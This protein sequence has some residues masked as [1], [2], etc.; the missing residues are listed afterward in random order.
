M[1]TDDE[2]PGRSDELPHVPPLHQA[3]LGPREELHP[4]LADPLDAVHGVPVAVTEVRQPDMARPSSLVKEADL[5]VIAAGSQET[6]FSLIELQGGDVAGPGQ[7]GLVAG[8]DGNVRDVAVTAGLAMAA[9][10]HGAAV[11]HGHHPA[12]AGGGLLPGQTTDRSSS[13]GEILQFA[14]DGHAGLT[15]SIIKYF[16]IFSLVSEVD[17]FQIY[18]VVFLQKF[19]DS[20]CQLYCCKFKQIFLHHPTEIFI[21]GLL[22]LRLDVGRP[23]ALRVVHAGPHLALGLRVTVGVG[24]GLVVADL[25]IS[26]RLDDKPSAERRVR[27]N[28][29]LAH[30]TTVG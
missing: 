26:V 10:E 21:L 7:Q 18:R 19:A 29:D 11:G 23:A 3:V 9:L 24:E 6:D 22:V 14:D 28:V 13:L 27:S 12:R 2:L 5:A 8:G 1:T 30:H 16:P 4:G 17:L 15:V 20:L 25:L